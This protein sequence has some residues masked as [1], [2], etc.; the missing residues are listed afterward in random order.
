MDDLQKEKRVTKAAAKKTALL[1]EDAT[2]NNHVNQNRLAIAPINIQEQ[3]RL[4]FPLFTDLQ[5]T[6]QSI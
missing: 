5:R 6:L 1:A 2:T 3:F 4:V